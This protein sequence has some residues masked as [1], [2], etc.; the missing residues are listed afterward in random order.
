MFIHDARI[1]ANGDC[2]VKPATPSALAMESKQA[3]IG[4]LPTPKFLADV[5]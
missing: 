5:R 4:A 2:R 3:L 1:E